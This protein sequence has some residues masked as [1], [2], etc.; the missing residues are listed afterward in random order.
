[1]LYGQA[2]SGSTLY[3]RLLILT[4]LTCVLAAGLGPDPYHSADSHAAMPLLPDVGP[5]PGPLHRYMSF[6]RTHS[7]AR[8]DGCMAF[9]RAIRKPAVDRLPVQLAHV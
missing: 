9:R 8:T 5:L 6:L 4:E 2:V 1:M 3:V 7:G